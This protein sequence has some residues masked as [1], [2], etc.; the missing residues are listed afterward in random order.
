[1]NKI[2]ISLTLLLCIQLGTYAQHSVTIKINELR[3]SKGNIL[4]EL[5]TDKEVVIRKAK[6]NIVGNSCTIRL[7]NIKSGKYTFRYVH[8]ENNNNEMDT[9]WIGMPVEGVGFS[10]NAKSSFGPPDL[11]DTFFTVDNDKTMNCTVVYIGE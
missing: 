7:D 5:S 9:N 8:D 6:Q 2:V 1:M 11:E 4:L 10:N 3:S